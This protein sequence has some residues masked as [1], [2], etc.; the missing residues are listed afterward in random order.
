MT[1]PPISESQPTPTA[2]TNFFSV[3]DTTPSIPI[4]PIVETPFSTSAAPIFGGDSLFSTAGGSENATVPVSNQQINA[5]NAFIPDLLSDFASA[6]GDGDFVSAASPE[7]AAQ[8]SSVEHYRNENLDNFAAATEAI[9]N[10]GDAFDAFATKFD[11][12]AEPEAA[13]D[14]FFDAFGSG[15]VAMDTSS[16]GEVNVT[17]SKIL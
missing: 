15:Q 8:F 5:R 16:D 4:E 10:T 3:A 13:V 12:A 14:S 17:Y 2:E 11:K 7:L 9:Q 1:E 6:A